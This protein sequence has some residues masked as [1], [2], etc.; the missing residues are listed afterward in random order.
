MLD[1]QQAAEYCGVSKSFLDKARCTG[2]GPTF[3]AIGR[4]RLYSEGDLDAW[5]AERRRR[6]TSGEGSDAT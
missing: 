6:S 1:V 4:R 3:H 2:D 5:L